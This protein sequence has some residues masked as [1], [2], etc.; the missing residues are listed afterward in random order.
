MPVFLGLTVAQGAPLVNGDNFPLPESYFP[1]LKSMIDSAAKQAPRILVRNSENALAEANRITARAGQLPSAGGY[2]SY[3]PWVTETRAVAGSTPA[4]ATNP[5]QILHPKKLAYSFNV[6]QPVY[7]WGALRDNTRIG[8]LQQKLALGVSADSYRIL[9]EEIRAQYMQVVVNKAALARSRFNTRL[10][11]EQLALARSKF[12][13]NVI[14][15][16]D[17]FGPTI[18]AEQA[19][20]A[21][22]RMS[23]DYENSRIY[24]SKL[25]G[26]P[27]LSDEQVPTE[28]PPVTPATS[29]LQSVAA[30]FS[31][32]TDL[33]T[34]SLQNSRDQI[35]VERLNYKIASTRL[36]PNVN[37]QLGTTQ[38]EF[39]Y[40]V[41]IA[42]KYKVRSYYAGFSVNWNVF[43]GFAT[44][45]AKRSSLI[46]RRQLEQTY[47]EQT[48][49]AIAAVE[50][51]MRQLEFSAR[52]LSIVERT[53]GSAVSILNQRKEEMAR[54]VVSDADVNA[55]QLNFY[56]WQLTAFGARNEYML[57]T[58]KLLSTTLADP[59]LVNIPAAQ[60]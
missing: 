14:A 2:A 5:D 21:T 31:G 15:E 37:L 11:D 20:L 56:D 42:D 48:A 52:N 4:G 27:V 50:A 44:R 38:D 51:Q 53:L 57:R 35:E 54:G 40:S 33:N 10:A 59:A 19:R 58:S 25:S 6:I 49:D 46:R 36:R 3:Y 7:H 22:D 12:E 18:S 8:E 24:L 47:K 9:V 39:S 26:T 30:E 55:A 1:A 13:K 16:A 60:Q 17:L 23:E 29:A 32:H 34:Y 41:N 45:S 43:D 28:I